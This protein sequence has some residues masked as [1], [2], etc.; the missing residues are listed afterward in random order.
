MQGI[1]T[2]KM[3]PIYYFSMLAILVMLCFPFEI[4]SK[5]LKEKE[6][7]CVSL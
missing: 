5:I 4:N 2:M 6:A 7:F 1:K 3:L